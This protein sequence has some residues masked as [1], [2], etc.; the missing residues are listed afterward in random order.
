MQ[1]KGHWQHTYNAEVTLISCFPTTIRGR[2][3][4]S[5]FTAYCYHSLQ[6][7]KTKPLANFLLPPPPP[8]HCL[9][10][11]LHCFNFELKTNLRHTVLYNLGESTLLNKLCYS[12][13]LRHEGVQVMK[14]CSLWNP[15]LNAANSSL[16]V[17]IEQ[18]IFPRINKQ[19][20][21]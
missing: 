21:S 13:W 19:E 5:Q 2:V 7:F 1:D 3:W 20:I 15:S 4:E 17:I 9:L 6:N 14:A 8:R 18:L 10:Q 11:A 12:N 16:K